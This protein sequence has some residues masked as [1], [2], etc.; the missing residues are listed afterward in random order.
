MVFQENTAKVAISF[1]SEIKIFEDTAFSHVY[2]VSTN[3]I[4]FSID[5]KVL[6]FRSILAFL[7]VLTN[8]WGTFIS[9]WDAVFLKKSP[10]FSFSGGRCYI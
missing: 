9:K 3:K 4:F 1:F 2:E 7:N 5:F 6:K 8:F 10:F